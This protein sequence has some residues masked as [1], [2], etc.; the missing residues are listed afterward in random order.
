ML[1]TNSQ[2]TTYLRMSI[3]IGDAL[4][5]IQVPD[6]NVLVTTAGRKQLS[7]QING[8]ATQVA[9]LVQRALELLY[10]LSILNRIGSNHAILTYR[11]NEI[12][13]RLN[14]QVIERLLLNNIAG[15]HKLIASVYWLTGS[16]S[17]HW[18]SE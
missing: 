7:I 17:T 8:H 9:I 14:F 4:M 15:A 16:S 3:N 6:I 1:V 10:L 5:R 13:V 12:V 18:N 2:Q 11:I